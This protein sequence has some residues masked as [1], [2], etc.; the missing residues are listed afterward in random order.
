[1]SQVTICETLI[2]GAGPGGLGVAGMLAKN[3]RRALILER[4]ERVGEAWRRRY[5]ALRLNSLASFSRL[6]GMRIDRRYGIYPSRDEF[7]S[8]LEEYVA[9]F[10]LEVRSGTEARHVE[11]RDGRWAVETQDGEFVARNLVIATG[12]DHTPWMPDWPGRDEFEGTLMHAAEFRVPEPFRGLDVLVVG[13]GNTGS[14]LAHLLAEDGAGRVRVAVRTPPNMMVRTWHGI[15]PYPGGLLLERLPDRLSD[16]LGRLAQRMTVGDLSVYGLPLPPDGMKTSVKRGVPPTV[17][18]GFVE[19]VKSGAVEIVAAV[20]GFDAADVLLADG[21][22]VS[23]DVVIAATGYR[24]NL[25]RL[26]SG[27]ASVDALGSPV[28]TRDC[29]AVGSPGLY[30]V[31][32]W[33]G[34][35]GPLHA[36]RKQAKRVALAIAARE[37]G[38]TAH[39]GASA[40]LRAVSDRAAAPRQPQRS[41]LGR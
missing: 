6:P 26:V 4:G 14:E 29:E 40:T 12:L 31:G 34:L 8:Y 20:T 39:A 18:D 2:V 16:K 17:V 23:P 27:F 11:P 22:R 1:M 9:R 10:Q 13:C 38:G 15:S 3:G 7:V 36:M 32:Y 33:A 41:T 35:T 37:A 21:S 19:S 30:F 5:D 25:E 28:V 24:R